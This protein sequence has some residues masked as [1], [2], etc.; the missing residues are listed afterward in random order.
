MKILHL[1]TYDTKGGAAKGCYNLFKELKT[2]SDL[3]IKLLVQNK[4]SSDNDILGPQ[5]DIQ[6]YFNTARPFIDRAF[7]KILNPK[8]PKGTYFHPAI[9][10]NK[11]ILK[12]IKEFEPDILHL[13]WVAGGFFDYKILK[14]INIPVIWTLRDMW[15]FTGGCHYSSDCQKYTEYCHCC[16]T[17]NSTFKY[18]ASYFSF[19][20]K[21]KAYANSKIIPVGISNWIS[22]CARKSSLLKDKPV[23]VIHNCIDT[24]IFKPF[25]KTFSREVFSL[26]EN[27]KLLLFGAIKSLEDTR[28]GFQYLK[29]ALDEIANSEMKDE[30]ELV[31]FG[32]NQQSDECK[33]PFRVHYTGYINDEKTLSLLYSAVDAMITPS[34]QEAFGKTAAEALACGVPVVAFKETALDEIIDHKING[35]LANYLNYKDLAKG[36]TWIL[37]N[38]DEQ[39]SIEARNKAIN[40]F[41]LRVSAKK[42]YDLYLNVLNTGRI[43]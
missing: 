10:P 38:K 22:D 28:K 26:P 31:V 2:Y 35:Y 5:N 39:I 15:P 37:D 3:D 33:Y 36:I 11:L 41:S 17:L 1:S 20:K 6:D 23:Y 13:H 18:D 30:I 25:N 24:D 29:L 42:Y 7:V 9:L 4:Y 21:Q 27:K 8:T 14:K 12:T 19:I 16:P 43:T 34:T 40:H 32:D